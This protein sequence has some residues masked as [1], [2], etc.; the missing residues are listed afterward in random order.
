MNP[1]H[2]PRARSGGGSGLPGRPHA[3]IWA[4]SK[5]KAYISNSSKHNSPNK[6]K[7]D[8]EKTSSKFQEED[9]EEKKKEKE[10]AEVI[11]RDLQKQQENRELQWQHS[12]QQ[13]NNHDLPLPASSSST[14][15]YKKEMN[16]VLRLIRRCSA[17]LAH[18]VFWICV[19][20]NGDIEELPIFRDEDEPGHFKYVLKY[21][22]YFLADS[23][24]CSEFFADIV[25]TFLPH[26]CVLHHH[27]AADALPTFA[28][29]NA[30]FAEQCH[31]LMRC[32]TLQE[33][34]MSDEMALIFGHSS[35]ES[36]YIID[37]ASGWMFSRARN[38]LTAML[39]VRGYIAM[40]ESLVA[41]IEALVNDIS[42]A[43]HGEP[44]DVGAEQMV[45][46]MRTCAFYSRVNLNLFFLNLKIFII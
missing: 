14:K 17:C 23:Y 15:Y 13:F 37:A 8:K 2:R 34:G 26:P 32:H 46:F 27:V 30:R 28:A 24:V 36:T 40:K 6:S 25:L 9:E 11:R 42:C 33:I 1:H 18:E 39:T 38:I 43:G 45:C 3:L 12:P 16:N 19:G 5:P 31:T 4:N 35:V 10:K 20:N 21:V 22:F 41:L 29:L 7:S 44:H